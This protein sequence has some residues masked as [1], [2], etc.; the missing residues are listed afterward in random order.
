[1]GEILIEKNE[2]ET[3]AQRLGRM[4]RYLRM[5][6]GMKREDFANYLHIPLGTVRDW[7]QGKRK[8]PEYLYELIEYKVTRELGLGDK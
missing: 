7:E 6:T 5:S 4:V 3:E 8:M 1:M 2:Q